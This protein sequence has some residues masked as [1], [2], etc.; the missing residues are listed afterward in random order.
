[1]SLF[2]CSS[3]DIGPIK[4]GW[5]L[6]VDG[7]PQ[8]LNK[9]FAR[10]DR[11]AGLSFLLSWIL[12]MIPHMRKQKGSWWLYLLSACR[13]QCCCFPL[14]RDLQVLTIGQSG[15]N[16]WRGMVPAMGRHW[17]HHR[18]K[19]LKNRSFL[20]TSDQLLSHYLK[21]QN[22]VTKQFCGQKID[23][24]DRSGSIIK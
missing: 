2:L 15:S 12:S 7:Y 4:P 5:G 9:L 1:M 23:T 3:A 6:L 16:L 18:R 8:P 17:R 24:S 20:Y 19:R 13:G 14:L 21:F 11:V 22:T 10:Q